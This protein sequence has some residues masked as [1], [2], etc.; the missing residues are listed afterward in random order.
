MTHALPVDDGDALRA[1][2]PNRRKRHCVRRWRSRG[3]HTFSFCVKPDT[4]P[5]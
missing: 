3:R 5:A 4:E 1:D 2:D